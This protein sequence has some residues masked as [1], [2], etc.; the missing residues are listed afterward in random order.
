MKIAIAEIAGAAIGGRPLKVFNFAKT[1]S[2]L[3]HQPEVFFN[4]EVT[5]ELSQHVSANKITWNNNGNKI[6]TLDDITSYHPDIILANSSWVPIP[7]DF[8]V[9]CNW[10][11][12]LIFKNSE[13]A[14]GRKRVEKGIPSP[15]DSYGNN[16][17]DIWY[18]CET[19]GR[20]LAQH[21]PKIHQFPNGCIPNPRDYSIFRHQALPWEKRTIQV[22]TV[23]RDDPVKGLDAFLRVVANQNYRPFLIVPEKKCKIPGRSVM[24]TI[25][26]PSQLFIAEKLGHAKI[27]LHLPVCDVCPAAVIEALNAGCFVVT[28]RNG[29]MDEIVGQQGAIVNSEQEASEVINKLLN[30]QQETNHI[31]NS[32]N[33]GCKWD[34]QS[35]ISRIEKHLAIIEKKVI[36]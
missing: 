14:Y 36:K 23:T 25:T 5:R 30:N 11:D 33:Q 24:D 28:N 12:T 16:L 21:H 2:L 31:Q 7:K 35:V 17:I 27:F 1:F 20:L 29:S 6:H 10:I 26:N 19:L 32:I 8:P 18:Q 4:H 22:I 34:R 13:T 9:I 15:W 3:G